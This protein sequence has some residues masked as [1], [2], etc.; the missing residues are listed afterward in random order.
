[1]A[2]FRERGGKVQARVQ[3]GEQYISK[4]F[5][6]KKD[7][8]LWARGVEREIDLGTYAPPASIQ[9]TVGDLLRRYCAEV[10]PLHRGGAVEAIRL[11]AMERTQLANIPLASATAKAMAAY[12]DKRLEQVSPA[13]VLRELQILSSLFNH[14]RREWEYQIANP[15]A[16]IRKP[17]PSRGRDRVLEHGEEGRLM[18]AL[19]GGGRGNNGQF[20]EGT[21]N[22]WIKPLVEFALESACR[23]G[24][25]L[26]LTWKN[27]DIKKRVAYLDITKNG[28]KRAVPLSTKALAILKSL[29]RRNDGR[30]FPITANSL[31]AAWNRAVERAG[32]EDL[33]L[34]DLRHV[35]VTRLAAKL[36][37]LIELAAVSGHKDLKMLRRYYHCRPEELALKLG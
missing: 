31:K 24:E 3:R 8:Q 17:S 29:P 20:H 25:L 1:M 19:S 13:T 28:D 30:I 27:V 22:P 12:R 5:G 21:R 9:G 2:T 6:S 15:V 18:A 26:A 23:R 32:I 34:H 37:N 10:S 35:A 7:A 36:P 16:D 14:A 11:Q 33:H 4:S